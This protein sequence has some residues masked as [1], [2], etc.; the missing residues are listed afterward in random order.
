MP[1]RRLS[2]AVAGAPDPVD[3][4]DAD[5]RTLIT[6]SRTHARDYGQRQVFVRLD[7]RPQV[8]LLFGQSLTE[9][10]EPGAHRLRAHN[11]LV[12]RTISFTVES[13]EH[14]EF[15]LINYCS[16]FWQGM[17]GLLG[18]APIFLKIHRRSIV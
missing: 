16:L 15:I 9:M 17:A 6:I 5:V 11:T 14:L 13:G 12:R 3:E 8:A 18:A 4:L 7:D 10:V 1:P 2:D